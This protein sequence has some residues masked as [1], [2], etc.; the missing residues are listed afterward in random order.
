ML[1]EE[2]Q[3][4]VTEGPSA[5]GIETSA[6]ANDAP[7]IVVPPV[8]EQ[9]T[10]AL[11]PAVEQNT[12]APPQTVVPPSV[13][14]R[15]AEETAAIKARKDKDL[16]DKLHFGKVQEALSTEGVKNKIEDAEHRVTYFPVTSQ[17][18]RQ[19]ENLFVAP[20]DY[21]V[22]QQ[23][24]QEQA[25]IGIIYGPDYADCVMC[26]EHLGLL[27]TGQ[28]SRQSTPDETTDQHAELEAQVNELL[29]RLTTL[30]TYA[31]AS[32][33]AGMLDENLRSARLHGDT[34]DL[35]NT[36]SQHTL[37]LNR[38]AIS[39]LGLSLK[40]L[41]RQ[42]AKAAAPMRNLQ[43][44][45]WSRDDQQPLTDL[46]K[47][48]NENDVYV[49]RRP[50]A[51]DLDFSEQIEAVSA[52]LHKCNISLLFIQPRVEPEL[53][54]KGACQIIGYP[55]IDTDVEREFIQQTFRNYVTYFRTIIPT[56]TRDLLD[57]LI[58]IYLK[59]R[60][61]IAGF[62]EELRSL[63][64]E[65]GEDEIRT[66]AES[67][68]NLDPKYARNRF[69]SW[70]YNHQLY[71]MLIIL[72]PDVTR[73]ILDKIYMAVVAELR[74]SGVTT[75]CDPREIGMDDL[76][77]TIRAREMDD[78][79]IYFQYALMATEADRQ[80]DNH[81]HL[82]WSLLKVILGWVDQ[83]RA[84]E[85]WQ[86][87]KSLG[88]ALGRMG[89]YQMGELTDILDDLARNSSGGVVVVAS[90]ALDRICR[91]A[92]DKHDMVVQILRSWAESGDP[93]LMWAA[94]ASIWR[95]Y[96][97]LIEIAESSDPHTAYRTLM[98]LDEIS[99]IFTMLVQT[100]KHF[101][102]KTHS[103]LWQKAH[104]E[105]LTNRAVLEFVMYTLAALAAA[106]LD[107]ILH[108]VRQIAAKH[109]AQMVAQIRGWLQAEN[110]ENQRQIGLLAG[111]QLFE[112]N[113]RPEMPLSVQQQLPLLGLIEPLLTTPEEFDEKQHTVDAVIQTLLHWMSYTDW[114]EQIHTHLLYLLNRST[115]EVATI[116]CD[117]IARYWLESDHPP[118][119]ALGYALIVRAYAIHG[120]PLAM[121]DSHSGLLLLDAA[122]NARAN[123]AGVR[124]G[125]TFY[126]RLA[127]RLDLYLQRMGD[128]QMQITPQ[129][130]ITLADLRPYH[131]FPTLMM[132]PLE[133]ATLP[134]LAFILALTWDQ[135]NDIADLEE[136]RANR[137]TVAFF[138]EQTLE[139]Q[140]LWPKQAKVITVHRDGAGWAAVDQAV[141]HLL[142]QA[143]LKQSAAEWW[144]GLQ[145][146]FA[147]ESVALAGNA[148][149]DANAVV[150]Q[151]EAWIPCLDQLAYNRYPN[152]LMRIMVYT[153]GWLTN[154]DF[155]LCIATLQ[156]WLE[157]DDQQQRL[158]GIACGRFLYT[159]LMTS[160]PPPPLEPYAQLLPLAPLLGQQNWD[161]AQT[162]LQS[163]HCWSNDPEWRRR[164]L[165][166]PNGAAGELLTLIDQTAATYTKQMTQ[167]FDTWRA[168]NAAQEKEQ[169]KAA[170]ADF[171]EQL[172]LRLALSS[173]QQG[174]D[175]LAENLYGLIIVDTAVHNPKKRR[176][177]ANMTAKIIGQLTDK[178][179]QCPQPHLQLLVYWLG[180]DHLVAGPGEKPTADILLPS[181]GTTY[182]RLVGPLLERFTAP[183]LG[184]VLIATDE[185]P[186]DAEDW[187][188]SALQR[189]IL[190]YADEPHSDRSA[191]FTVL[192]KE[193][194]EE[195]KTIAT[196]TNYLLKR[197]GG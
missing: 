65:A 161:A 32:N 159:V 23:P 171:V 100:F 63:E 86:L 99:H 113:A 122:D 74:S 39:T 82:L 129:Q 101:N 25:R 1:I 20:P 5:T 174:L 15:E 54:V 79:R 185:L 12:D 19:I 110:N 64:D 14:P 158:V 155:P 138:G 127:P 193:E 27:L 103:Q 107:A 163:A 128:R 67:M 49:V 182:P 157:S 184:F 8:V 178:L 94:G 145:P 130:P 84:P 117:S 109:P 2:A 88:S 34:A 26:A 97:S 37:Q 48:L 55:P 36:R 177:L 72:F 89:L 179:Q 162:V 181:D 132:P 116:L 131:A 106:N 183:Q 164:L 133:A 148:G 11:P 121:P 18:R 192:P 173:R 167:L 153:V 140:A 160:E 172:R 142:A 93:D 40:Q 189:H 60:F 13:E 197:I 85:Y 69:R 166:Q 10:D 61:P 124:T 70:S 123:Q 134:H 188:N 43:I 91:A 33:L 143:L 30:P 51:V 83:Y 62:F 71:A 194:G 50:V 144:A 7:A 38:L 3:E 154:V 150:R 29:R 44:L 141:T 156:R 125:L 52:H 46:V 45:D 76:L 78:R 169:G 95:I 115:L 96:D 149:N 120:T 17:R 66:L 75:L 191:M 6:S 187:R 152:D 80:I 151:L 176:R 87:R 126:R 41:R 73:P 168:N 137:L 136:S 139:M 22:Q 4:T 135:V 112:T 146:Y 59:G 28:I 108:A 190:F 180:R 56:V 111:C 68:G 119:S 16:E 42:P 147:A 35:Q 105:K 47:Y 81:H 77:R 24:L 195:D 21:F 98:T 170:N 114:T 31:L 92:P 53:L 186:N 104:E 90:Y 58:T 118:A 57:E 175:V 196:I 9:R 165:L 102:G